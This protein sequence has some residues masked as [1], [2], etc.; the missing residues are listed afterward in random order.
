MTDA[1]S[2]PIA[3]KKKIDQ[4]PKENQSIGEIVHCDDEIRKAAYYKWEAQG[5]PCCD[6]VDFWLEAEAELAAS[7]KRLPA[8]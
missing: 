1:K 3:S 2:A 4:V 8:E 5:C 6:G 7:T